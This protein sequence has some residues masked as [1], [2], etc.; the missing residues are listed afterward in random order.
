MKRK[1]KKALRTND[2][3]E[4]VYEH[5]AGV[6]TKVVPLVP[7]TERL[8]DDNGPLT[9]RNIVISDEQENKDPKDFSR[10]KSAAPSK[11][12]KAVEE[13]EKK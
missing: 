3:D 10:A 11:E 7:L 9:S 8:G 2:D 13:A 4:S 12:N 1:Q 5:G 6:K